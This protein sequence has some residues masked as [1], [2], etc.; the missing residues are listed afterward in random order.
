MPKRKQTKIKNHRARKSHP[1]HTNHESKIINDKITKKPNSN[2]TRNRSVPQRHRTKTPTTSNV[3][4]FWPTSSSSTEFACTKSIT[5]EFFPPPLSKSHPSQLNFPDKQHYTTMPLAKMDIIR[6]KQSEIV[7]AL[8]TLAKYTA[9][10]YKPMTPYQFQ[11]EL[12]NVERMD[13]LC[14][15]ACRTAR[16]GQQLAPRVGP[17]AYYYRLFE[18]FFEIVQLEYDKLLTQ[19][20]YLQEHQHRLMVVPEPPPPRYTNNLLHV[21]PTRHA[22]TSTEGSSDVSQ[23]PTGLRAIVDSYRT[24]S[25]DSES[26]SESDRKSEDE[27]DSESDSD[28]DTDSDVEILS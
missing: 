25:D 20:E 14:T 24:S 10:V 18:D 12:Q 11:L 19:K 21:T 28:S 26:D 17:Y 9:K 3:T 13:T 23:T 4:E 16:S 27:S 2:V 6:T 8:V 22:S 7:S 15:R 5:V 1:D